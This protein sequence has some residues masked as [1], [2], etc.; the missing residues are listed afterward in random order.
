MRPIDDADRE[1]PIVS[2]CIVFLDHVANL[3]D[4]SEIRLERFSQCHPGGGTP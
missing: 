1:S 3:L 2:L 4:D